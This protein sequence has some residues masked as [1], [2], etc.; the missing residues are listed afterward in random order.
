MKTLILGIAVLGVLSSCQ[1]VAGWVGENK[2]TDSTRQTMTSESSNQA[3]F[4][5]DETI[6][7]ENAYSDLFLDSAALDNYIRQ[8]N[9]AGD[10]ADRMRE[11]YLVRNN[12]FAWFTSDGMTEQAKG[13]WSL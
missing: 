9:I 7:K 3:K 12:Q 6:T 1:Q 11:F 4:V 13:L 2:N 8:K 10:E 5:R